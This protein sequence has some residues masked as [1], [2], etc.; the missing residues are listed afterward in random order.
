MV[1]QNDIEEKEMSLQLFF[2][3]H[4]TERLRLF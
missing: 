3:C 1:Q 2:N 4:I